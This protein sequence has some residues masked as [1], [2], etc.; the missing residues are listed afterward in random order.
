MP[1]AWLGLAEH[2]HRSSRPSETRTPC[3]PPVLVLSPSANSA[4]PRGAQKR[5]YPLADRAPSN[6]PFGHASPPPRYYPTPV[7]TLVLDSHHYFYTPALVHNKGSAGGGAGG[8]GGSTSYGSGYY[9]SK[10][11]NGYSGNRY[12]RSRNGAS[13]DNVCCQDK[14]R[15]GGSAPGGAINEA[16]M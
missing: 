3:L 12:Y 15:D 16:C 14:D 11:A 6:S 7:R 8:Y 10:P 5:W 13:S 2:Q 1:Q 9:S 4:W